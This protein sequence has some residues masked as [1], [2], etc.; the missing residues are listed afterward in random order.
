M[1]EATIHGVLAPALGMVFATVALLLVSTILIAALRGRPLEKAPVDLGLSKLGISLRGDRV[2]LLA[3][4]SCAVAVVPLAIWYQGYRARLEKS[5]LALAKERERTALTEQALDRFKFYELWVNPKLPAGVDVEK[6]RQRVQIVIGR[7][8][9]GPPKLEAPRDVRV[10]PANDLWV[11][12]DRLNPGDEL[13]I[14]IQ[15]DQGSWTSETLQIP[16]TQVEMRRQ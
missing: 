7:P 14:V 11:H 9:G 12:V 6:L 1:S 3:L 16:R 4:L 10:G 5:E 15:A 13:R 8:G 2:T